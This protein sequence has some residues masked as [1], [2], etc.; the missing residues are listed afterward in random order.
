MAVIEVNITSRKPYAEGRAFGDSGPYERIEGVLTFAV[1]PDSDA[2]KPIVDLELAP[3]DS[4]GRVR[5]QSDFTLITPRDSSSGNCRLIVDV[6]NRGRRRVVST[7]NRAPAMPDGS[8]EVHPGD[9]FLF[10]HG[11]S[12]VSIGW[13]WDVYRSEAVLGLEAPCAEIDG[14]PV[15][16][17]A[18]VEIRPNTVEKTRLLANRLHKPYPVVDLDDPN[19]VLLV[20]DWEDGPDTVVPRSQ[21][22]FA[23]ETENGVVPSR[24]HVYLEPGFQPGKIYYIAYT[25]EG[26]PVVGTGL[27]AVRDVAVWLRHPSSLNPAKEGFERVYGYGVSQTGRM[28]RH[29]MYQ[30]LNLDEEDRMV[31]DGLLPHVAGGRRGEFNH[32]F[33]QPSQQ[34]APGFGQLF[35]F[36]D[37]EMT[38]PLTERKDGLLNRLRELNAV[39][40]IIYTNSSAEYWRGDGSL[41]HIDPA[42]RED[43]EPATESRIY[44]FAG[45]QH[46]AGSLAQM[47]GGGPD[48]SRGRYPFNVVDY[49]PLLRAALINLDRWVSDGIEPPPSKHLRLDDGTAVAQRQMLG[50]FVAIPGLMKPDPDR[51]WVV[52]EVDLGP[53]AHRGV[54]RY[55]VKEGRAYPCFVPATDADG[56]ELGGIRL[57]DLE[58]PV[59]THAGWNLRAPETGA[60]EQIIPMQGFTNFFAPIKSARE[61]A[62]DPRPSIEER[63]ESRDAYLEQVRE[64]ARRLAGDRYILEEDIDIVVAACAER[65][66]AAV[67]GALSRAAAGDS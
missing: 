20:W 34:S 40:R 59:G 29:F 18:V 44:H 57:P 63:Y 66:D 17:Q 32:R 54:G 13:Q 65:Y 10:R 50:S 39:P 67:A 24:E 41:A 21:W 46:G 37:N 64:V 51:L 14:K 30:G 4:D 25:A 7:F 49:R 31:Y 60:P 27:L 55:P 47:N 33:A 1:D 56:N 12:V 61:A 38:D 48:G 6:V 45:T 15:R 43:L 3:R 28:L 53:E 16:G 5:F 9:G 19:A 52:R 22:R 23:R 36:A 42:S 62:G 8:S 35:P 58:V 26:A 2:N 11:Y